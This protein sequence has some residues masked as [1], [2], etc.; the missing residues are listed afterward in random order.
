LVEL[1]GAPDGGLKPTD[2]SRKIP[3]EDATKV[4]KIRPFPA[5][6]RAFLFGN[7]RALSGRAEAFRALG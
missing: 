3:A 6:R 5:L 7:V 2:L 1:A 4:S